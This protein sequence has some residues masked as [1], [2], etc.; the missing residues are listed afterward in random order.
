MIAATTITA[1]GATLLPPT[2]SAEEDYPPPDEVGKIAYPELASV[3]SEANYALRYSM[4][5]VAADP[6]RQYPEGSVEADLR[7]GVLSLSDEYRDV[8]VSSARKML[9]DENARQENF[10]QFAKI[11]PDRYAS[12][13]FAKVFTPETVEFD[14]RSLTNRL[15]DRAKELEV[16]HDEEENRAKDIANKLQIKFPLPKLSSLDLRIDRVRCI[17][18]TSDL[19]E[20]VNDDRIDIGGMKLDHRGASRP[21]APRMVDHFHDGKVKSYSDPGMLFSSHDLSVSGEWPRTYFA[22]VMLAEIDDGGGFSQAISNVWHTVRAKVVEVIVAWIVD[23]LKGYLGASFAEAIGE[24]AAWLVNAF[25][26]WV[27]Q[28]FNDDVFAPKTVRVDLPSPY[29]FMYSAHY[30]WTNHRL[31]TRTLT[32]A[33]F[34][35]LYKVDVHWQVNR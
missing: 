27:A 26:G 15:L 3:M 14:A 12:L 19:W 35:G 34:D 18:E 20:W 16:A 1:L 31:P 2:A 21:V 13:G 22:V 32:Y 4:A 25:F 17:D 5:L 23:L 7:K 10:G 6:E 8:V 28:L 24:A 29:E 11:D 9:D 30:G 33:G